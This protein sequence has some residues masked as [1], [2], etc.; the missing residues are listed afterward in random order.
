MNTKQDYAIA[1]LIGFLAG[2]FAIPTAVN[3]GLHTR[4]V[5]IALPL[6]VPILFIAGVYIGKF[7]ARKFAFFEQLTKFFAVGFLNTAIDFGVLNLLSVVTGVT[8]GLIV[9]G[10]NIP[11][12]SVAVGNSY[13]WNKFW[14]FQGRAGGGA[15]QDFPRFLLVTL[16]GLFINSGIIIILTTYISAPSGISNTGWLNLAKIMATAISFMWNFL[17]YKF[18]V[19]RPKH[20]Q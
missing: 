13:F 12:F 14:V 18:I 15:L 5:L 7:I 1:A 10:V 9:G 4:I 8:S 2:V 20:E 16:I 19:F 11:G 3:N 6:I 17:G